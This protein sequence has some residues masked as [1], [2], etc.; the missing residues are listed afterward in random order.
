MIIQWKDRQGYPIEG[1][2]NNPLRSFIRLVC[3][4]IRGNALLTIGIDKKK[5]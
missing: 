2:I 3:Q 4:F 5:V 1:Y